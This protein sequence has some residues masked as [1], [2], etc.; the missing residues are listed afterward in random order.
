MGQKIH[1]LG[2]RLGVTK[3]HQSQWFA[4]DLIYPNLVIE[5]HFI[6]NTLFKQFPNG[7]ISK[8]EIQRKFDDQIQLNLYSTKPSLI[9][10]HYN[11]DLKNLSAQLTRKIYK[12]RKSGFQNIFHSEFTLKN[13]Y[14]LDPKVTVRIFELFNP[15]ANANFI[16]DSLVDELQKR[17]AFRRAIKK[18]LRRA[19]RSKV[20]GIKIQISGRLNGAEIARSEWAREG[21]IPL[22]TLR[23]EIDYCYRTAKTIYGILGVKVWVFKK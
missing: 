2:F 9:L 21:Q 7:S 20:R 16:A 4:N 10:A 1:P 5:D 15:D 18:T 17:V 8:I 12:N 13:L 6:R 14:S 23:A 3:T 11:N 22:Q 19:Q